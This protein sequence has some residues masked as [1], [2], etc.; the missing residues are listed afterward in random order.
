MEYRLGDTLKWVPM[1]W[2][3]DVVAPVEV[4]RLY[5]RGQALLSNGVIVDAHGEALI[6]SNRPVGKVEAMDLDGG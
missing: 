3:W 6:Y 2:K 1:F 4:V 5:R